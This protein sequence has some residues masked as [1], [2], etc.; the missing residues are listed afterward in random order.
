MKNKL[1]L[2]I[3]HGI[4]KDKYVL[5]NTIEEAEQDKNFLYDHLYEIEIK[6]EI[7]PWEKNYK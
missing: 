3:D 2:A 4:F 5:Y 1:Y 7:K 6:K